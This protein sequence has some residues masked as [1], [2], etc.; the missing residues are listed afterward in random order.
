M[1]DF[2]KI[3]LELWYFIIFAAVCLSCLLLLVIILKIFFECSKTHQ[4]EVLIYNQTKEPSAIADYSND[5]AVNPKNNEVFE[6]YGE[7]KLDE[8]VKIYENQEGRSSN[9][10]KKKK[11]KIV[12]EVPAKGPEMFVD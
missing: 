4:T 6:E 5:Y 12:Y 11:E 3:D 7:Y 2:K 8:I 9:T 1:V 10:M